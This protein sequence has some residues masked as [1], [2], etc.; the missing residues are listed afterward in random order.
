MEQLE[1]SDFIRQRKMRRIA[2]FLRQD[3]PHSWRDGRVDYLTDALRAETRIID[4]ANVSSL[5]YDADMQ[6]LINKHREGLVLD[7]GA[8]SKGQYL[9]NVYNLEIVPYSSTDVLAVGEYLPFKD[10]TFDAVLS[11]AV[12]EHVR[13]PFRCADEI[14]RVLKPGG[15]LLCAMPFMSP[16]HGYPHHY[17]NATPQ[18]HLRLFEE[19]LV[20]ANLTLPSACHPIFSL[21]W[22]LQCWVDGLKQQTETQAA[23]L[24]MRVADLLDSPWK[25]VEQPFSRELPDDKQLEIASG[26]VLSGQKKTSASSG[27]RRMKRM[28]DAV[29]AVIG[30][31]ARF[32]I[33]ALIRT[34]RRQLG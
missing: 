2:P 12:L 14:I 10:N 11:V 26:T 18:G 29:E 13:D 7:C 9:E 24:N 16:L 6:A 15:D 23:F 8:G 3:M 22:M 20:N 5:G 30:S 34:A 25:L 21:Q 4:T 33:G 31:S 1:S 27:Q 32:R 28:G 19:K 17:F